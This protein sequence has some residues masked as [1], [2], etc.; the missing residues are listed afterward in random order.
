MALRAVTRAL[1]SLSLT[2]RI[3]AVPG[4]SLL[5]AAQVTNNVLLQLPTA[6]MLLPCRLVLTSVALR[7]KFVSWKSRTK[8]TTMP[9]KMRKSGGRNHTGPGDVHSHSGPS[10][11][12]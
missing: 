9:V 4:P 11:Q 12:R 7:A 1:G 10:L 3:A 5:P 2:P 8:Y 6:S